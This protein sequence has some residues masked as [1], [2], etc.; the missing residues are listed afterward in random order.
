MLGV[1]DIRQELWRSAQPRFTA[2]SSSSSSYGCTFN[3]S[4]TE[5]GRYNSNKRSNDDVSNDSSGECGHDEEIEYRRQSN[6]FVNKRQRRLNSDHEEEVMHG[7]SFDSANEDS[8]LEAP[9]GGTKNKHKIH[10]Y[11]TRTS[12]N[13]VD[14]E[15][16]DS[17]MM[18]DSATCHCCNSMI[19]RD[20]HKVF[21]NYCLRPCCRDKCSG[22]CQ[23]CGESFCFYC[24]TI[25]YD[26][27]SERRFCLD[28]NR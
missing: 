10:D 2:P 8:M 18:I 3:G 20:S 26:M 15:R 14:S 19:V 7:N 11:F 28:C 22:E 16:N 9:A 13:T 4:G 21:C 23:S 25:N 5:S 6:Y 1:S 24:S 17:N 27:P 12:K